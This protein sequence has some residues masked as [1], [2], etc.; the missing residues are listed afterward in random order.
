MISNLTNTYPADTLNFVPNS[1]WT[2][3]NSMLVSSTSHRPHRPDVFIIV[4][5]EIRSEKP[6]AENG[7]IIVRDWPVGKFGFLV[8]LPLEI[9]H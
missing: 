8:R 9:L 3:H 5:G 2:I 1:F 6:F 7:R 4:V